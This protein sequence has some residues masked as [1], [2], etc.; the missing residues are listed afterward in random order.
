MT[1]VVRKQTY[2]DCVISVASIFASQGLLSTPEP[3]TETHVE[4]WTIQ[5]MCKNSSS[6]D[7]S[8]CKTGSFMSKHVVCE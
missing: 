6:T 1:N 3:P 2:S 7:L 5:F 8:Y 4:T